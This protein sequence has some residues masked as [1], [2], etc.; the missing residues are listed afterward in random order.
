MV[1][2]LQE[3][4]NEFSIGWE[5]CLAQG[6]FIVACVDGRGTGGQAVTLKKQTYLSLGLLESQDQIEAAEALG[7][8]PYIDAS[9]MGIFGW[10][11]GGYTVL[12]SMMRGEGTFAAG[13][14]VAPPTDWALYDYY[15]YRAIYAYSEG[16]S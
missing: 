5:E 14:A 1:L 9:R 10:S 16:K 15:L 7:A 8:L 12:M 4:L 2:A 11:F 3:V 13:V 6:R